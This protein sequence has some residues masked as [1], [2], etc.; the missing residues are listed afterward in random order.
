MEGGVV[1][2][3]VLTSALVGGERQSASKTRDFKPCS[4]EKRA[5]SGINASHKQVLNKHTHKFLRNIRMM[6]TAHNI[7]PVA[8]KWTPGSL[9]LRANRPKRECNYPLT[10][11]TYI[12]NT[13]VSISATLPVST[14]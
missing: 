3:P 4:L 7:H 12:N 1:T 9:S 11:S 10:Y 8:N 13:R 5:S 14:F 6:Y 2:Q